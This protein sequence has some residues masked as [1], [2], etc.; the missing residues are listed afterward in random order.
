MLSRSSARHDVKR[1]GAEI[2]LIDGD[3]FQVTL[4]APGD[5]MNL[6]GW[7]VNDVLMRNSWRGMRTTGTNPTLWDTGDPQTLALLVERNHDYPDADSL[8]QYT[9]EQ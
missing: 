7:I 3:L 5:P 2:R 4:I 1:A 6:K 8:G 9:T